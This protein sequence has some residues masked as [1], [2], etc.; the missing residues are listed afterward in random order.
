MQIHVY[1]PV[2]KKK[3]N[4]MRSV[5]AK[6]KG[7]TELSFRKMIFFLNRYIYKTL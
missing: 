1:T 2:Q 6:K 5:D 3:N 7:N 4:K